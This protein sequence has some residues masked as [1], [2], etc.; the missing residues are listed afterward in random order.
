[1]KHFLLQVGCDHS[2]NLVD[3]CGEKNLEAFVCD[4]LS[5]PIRSGSCDACISIA[6]IHHFS[7]AVSPPLYTV[8]LLCRATNI[9]ENLLVWAP[10][11]TSEEQNGGKSKVCTWCKQL[12]EQS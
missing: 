3:I 1:M 6:V 4:A 12:S 10:G 5:V 7:T 8:V 2:K 11:S 9:T